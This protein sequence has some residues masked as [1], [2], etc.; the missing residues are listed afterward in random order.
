MGQ[1]QSHDTLFM[2]GFIG[3][4]EDERVG[5]GLNMRWT[6]IMCQALWDAFNSQ[7]EEELIF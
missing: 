3:R 4:K 2:K 1:L 6:V 5:S 7:T